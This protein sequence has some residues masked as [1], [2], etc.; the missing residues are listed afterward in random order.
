MLYIAQQVGARLPGSVAIWPVDGS[1][2]VT[3]RGLTEKVRVQL[4]LYRGISGN[5]LVKISRYLREAK[6]TRDA[7]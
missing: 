4:N 7:W 5:L 1:G 2:T 3:A 6:A